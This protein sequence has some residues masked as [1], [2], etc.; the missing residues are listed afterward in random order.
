MITKLID[1]NIESIHSLLTGA[2][3]KKNIVKPESQPDIKRAGEAAQCAGQ[4]EYRNQANQNRFPAKHV[5]QHTCK[6]IIK[7][8]TITFAFKG[9]LINYPDP[10]FYS[11]LA[12]NLTQFTTQMN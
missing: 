4:A 6:E 5:R 9:L 10:L 3:L 1:R 8:Q 12:I 11:R 2:R 7:K